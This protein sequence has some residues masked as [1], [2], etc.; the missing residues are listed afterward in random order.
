ML[1]AVLFDLDDTLLGNDMDRFLPGYFGLLGK[2]AEKYL[3]RDQFLQELLASTEAMIRNVDPTVSNRDVFWQTFEQRTG[4]KAAELEPFFEQFYRNQFSQLRDRTEKRPFA[5]KLVQ[6]CLEQN[7]AVVVATNP[8]FPR[9]A[10]DARLDWAG[11]PV[12]EYDFALVTTYENMHAAKPQPAYY[13]EIL[14]KI[15]CAPENALMI[16]ND[17]ENDILP[18]HSIGLQTYWLSLDGESLP[19]DLSVPYGRSL[20]DV[21]DFLTTQPTAR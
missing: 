21:Y 11:L 12:T 17:W 7:L 8:L 9:I 19:T 4:L 10:I 16:G 1:K 15:E 14:D 13:S 5:T 6:Y 20:E 3:P 18:A 2:F